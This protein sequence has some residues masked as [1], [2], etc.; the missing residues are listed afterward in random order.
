MNFSP[1]QIAIATGAKTYFTGKPCRNG[2]VAYRYTQSSTCSDCVKGL[3]EP[4]PQIKKVLVEPWSNEKTDLI[5][6][7]SGK[8]YWLHIRY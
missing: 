1:R 5:P 8:G 4:R 7:P 3:R 6:D 2:H